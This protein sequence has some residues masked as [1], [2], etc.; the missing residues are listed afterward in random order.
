ARY[1]IA[2]LFLA[3]V[4]MVGAGLLYLCL[5]LARYREQL[6]VL[7]ADKRALLR[8][9]A[10]GCVGLFLSQITYLLA[11][12]YT[13]SGTATVLQCTSIVMIMVIGCLMERRRPQLRELLGLLCA[14]VAVLLIATKGDLGVL[15][16]PL[17][18]LVWGLISAVSAVIYTLMPKRLFEQW[19]SMPVV[20][21]GT[22]LGTIAALGSWAASGA[23]V[24]HFDAQGL[25]LMA[26]IIVL[27]TFGAFGLFLHGVSIVGG[28]KGSLL[29]A[30]EPVSATVFAAVWMGTPFVWA[31][32]VGLLLMI[33]TTFLVVTATVPARGNSVN[34]G[35]SG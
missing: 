13:N 10:F 29:G 34:G 4:R 20:G 9:A 24:T 3:S 26:A 28:V 12:R 32:W 2:P 25:L 5:L 23:P 27:G 16:I 22:L 21:M 33:A 35:E 30:I 31:D 14:L 11:I 19:G 8:V 18:G 17:L 7:L 15:H 1:D 6:K